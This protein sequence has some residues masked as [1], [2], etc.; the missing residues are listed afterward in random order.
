MNEKLAREVI[1]FAERHGCN[2]Y[3][4][5]DLTVVTTQAH[6]NNLDHEIQRD[7]LSSLARG[8]GAIATT[9]NGETTTQIFLYPQ[10]P[11]TDLDKVL[12]TKHLLHE[13]RHHI[14]RAELRNYYLEF[15]NDYMEYIEE[16][17][18]R[19]DHWCEIDAD[20]F[21]LDFIVNHQEELSNILNVEREFINQVETIDGEY[22]DFAQKRQEYQR[23]R[24]AE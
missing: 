15:Q 7:L 12:F 1:A 8:V 6:F 21:S 9:A 19:E 23:L 10:N 13:L 22:A 18:I 2:F 24:E 11:D 3:G 17:N 14:Q 4:D 20:K 16:G 5:Y